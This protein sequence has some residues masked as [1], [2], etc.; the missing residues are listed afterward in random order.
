MICNMC[1][2]V[3]NPENKNL[4]KLNISHVV[5]GRERRADQRV[6]YFPNNNNLAGQKFIPE[7]IVLKRWRK[8]KFVHSVARGFRLSP[9][10]WRAIGISLGK[11]AKNIKLFNKN[12]IE[13]NFKKHQEVIRS[14]NF[15][16]QSANNIIEIFKC[17]ETHQLQ[18]I[19]D[20]HLDPDRVKKYGTPDLFLFSEHKT[21]Q[22][23]SRACFVEVKRPNEPLSNDQIN[24]I[25]FLRNIGLR[26]RVF[27]LI[28]A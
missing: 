13:S 4:P 1:N 11:D 7:Q 12:E 15:K 24:E 14:K 3:E 28:E 17:L 19:L 6:I 8:R 23:I 21:T 9:N 25:N 10:F 20:R 27:R 5:K 2:K 22:S 26:S 18:L 16:I